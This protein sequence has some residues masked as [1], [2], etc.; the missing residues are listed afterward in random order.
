MRSKHRHTAWSAWWRESS[1]PR[2]RAVLLAAGLAA[3]LVAGLGTWQV[4]RAEGTPSVA[5]S[6]P[7]AVIGSTTPPQRPAGVSALGRST[8]V[9]IDI[10]SIKLRAPVDQVGLAADGM[11]AEQPLSRADRAAWYR[12]GPAPG[13]L[14]P[15]VIVGHVDTKK[16]SAVFFSLSQLR[17]GDPV[18]VTRADGHVVT[19]TVD[20]LGSYPKTQFPTK[21][22]YGPTN[23]PALRLITCG[24]RF[25]RSDGS[26][27]D[28]IVVFAHM[29]SES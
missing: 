8:P 13:Q 23:Y 6:L 22:V 25:D 24:G 12:L 14:G 20:W 29:A 21:L 7:Q 19:F 17:P 16:T 27:V 18:V 11:M 5:P 15:A 1:Q 2:R 28:N 3:L 9:R 26:Y 10:A 4:W